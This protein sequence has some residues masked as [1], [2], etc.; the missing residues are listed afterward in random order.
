LDTLDKQLQRMGRSAAAYRETYAGLGLEPV[1]SQ[2]REKAVI[3]ELKRLKG[4]LEAELGQL[5][6]QACAD[7]GEILKVLQSIPGISALVSG[8][9][10]TLL[11]RDVK[12]ASAW[13]AYVGLDVSVRESGQWKGRGRLTKR[14]NSYIRKRLFQCAWGAN[15]HDARVKAYYQQLRDSGRNYVEALNIIARKLLRIAYGVAI[16]GQPYDEKKAFPM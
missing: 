2:R 13:V 12:D 15:M 14:G 8:I 6:R 5:C 7:S 11:R 4:E 10:A 3:D 1:G 16:S 9:L